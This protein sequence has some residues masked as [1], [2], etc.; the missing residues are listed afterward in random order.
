M[1][2]IPWFRSSNSSDP[3]AKPPIVTN[4]LGRTFRFDTSQQVFALSCF[5]LGAGSAMGGAFVY[6]RFFRRLRSSGWVT[7]D[8]L[9]RKQWVR[10]V[11]TSVGDADNFRLYHTPAFGW[12]WRPIKF[13]WVPSK[14]KDLTGET[15]HIRIAGMDAPEAGH[16]GRE[17]QPYSAESLA[18]LKSKIEGK[19]LYCQLV[20]R[21]QYSRI[22]AVV[23]YPP[24][25]LPGTFFRG[26][27]LALEMLSAGWAE[28]YSLTGAEYGP[29]GK[30]EHERREEEAR[31][32]KRGMWESESGPRESAAEYKKRYRDAAA[33][34]PPSQSSLSSSEEPPPVR[35]Q[36]R[37]P[38]T[39][40]E[41][42]SGGARKSW[43]ERFFGRGSK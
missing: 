18:W 5:A 7:P 8:V 10:G 26:K 42:D 25:L 4:V 36:R 38:I 39:P 43:M 29:E 21:D 40:K 32:N 17:A 23:T 33:E 2:A 1:P 14:A 27:N 9:K 16:F 30:E 20:R 34:K 15:I 41:Q 3:P 24:Q 35:R 19:T 37:Q 11:V 13:R 6:R 12:R 28:V 31:K 22:V